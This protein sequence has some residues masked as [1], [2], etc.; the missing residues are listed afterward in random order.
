MI[1]FEGF[2]FDPQAGRL[3]QK[4]CN[5]PVALRHKLIQLLSY[6]LTHR[7]RIVSKEE[8]L[9]TL[10]E[11]GQYREHSLS[12]SIL[13]L[14]KVLGDA[15]AS[16]SYI[17]TVPNQGFQWICPVTEVEAASPHTLNLRTLNLRT[18]NLRTL[19]LHI[20][21]GLLAGAAIVLLLVALIV[22]LF[23]PTPEDASAEGMTVLVL[24][25]QNQTG[26]SSMNW[27]ELGLADMMASD[28]MLIDGLEV[29]TPAQISSQLLTDSGDLQASPTQIRQL[30]A[31]TS[32]DVAIQGTVRF[33]NDQQA[34]EYQ[35]IS[36]Q[37]DLVAGRIERQDLAVSMTSVVSELYRQL[38]P[39]GG[40]P[41]LPSYDYIPS[42]MHEYA[43]GVQALNNEGAILARYYFGASAQIDASHAWSVAYL[44]V[45]QLY[46]G[47]WAEAD[48]RF[49]QALQQDSEPTLRDFVSYWRAL[50]EYRRGNLPQAARLLQTVK[51]SEASASHDTPLAQLAD[52][53]S[54]HIAYLQS[55][56]GV[57]GVAMA[58]KPV[59]NHFI[60]SFP[61]LPLGE[62]ALPARV[63]EL[64]TQVRRLTI[65]GYQPAL[66]L[67]LV[68]LAQHPELSPKEQ[69]GYLEQALTVI[70]RLQQPHEHAQALLLAA[71][72]LLLHGEE[73]G[74][75]ASRLQDYLD[76][77]YRIAM[78]L[79]ARRL[80]A[81][82]ASY[83]QLATISDQL[84]DNPQQ[85]VDSLEQLRTTAA[86]PEFSTLLEQV[87]E[88]AR[89]AGA[90]A[91]QP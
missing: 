3:W 89:N 61:A 42:A 29:I 86:D 35:L 13:E 23:E 65:K 30:L 36:Q 57:G 68:T 34:L 62:T 72:S 2:R 63:S 16:P 51:T 4:D 85:A 75:D 88:H 26:T 15:A 22:V 73:S 44:G 76:R 49:E 43:R 40:T 21:P 6:L 90:M 53:L 79:D 71:R 52:R 18:L 58:D 84:A 5:E 87:S 27:V 14:R 70:A 41:D 28:L 7:E 20:P 83:Q 64:E 24:P 17:R 37:N 78:D 81:R 38:Q 91:F 80:A 59:P 39:N 48:A 33:A 47:Q 25:F 31:D 66:F 46:L 50:I 19:S 55:G 82:V 69:H 60:G 54:A 74:V 9:G 8:L 1:E 77:A 67:N 45:C 56:T 32:V 12:Q 10:W 11:H